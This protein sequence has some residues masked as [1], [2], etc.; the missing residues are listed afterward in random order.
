MLW[1]PA[2]TSKDNVKV[3]LLIAW[4][5]GCAMTGVGKFDDIPGKHRGEEVESTREEDR[6][7]RTWRCLQAS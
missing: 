4:L 1:P 3:E 2:Q 7:R 5:P 6:I